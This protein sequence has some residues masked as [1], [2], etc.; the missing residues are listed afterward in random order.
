MASEQ[1]WTRPA[2]P[3]RPVRAGL[4]FAALAVAL[5]CVGVAGLGAWNVQVVGQ[6][7]GPVRDTADGFFRELTAGDTGGA[8]GRLCADARSR[9]SPIGFAQWVRTPPRVTGYEIVNVSVATSGGRPRGTVRIRLTR[10]G[11]AEE[12][13]K[14]PVVKEDGRW[15][16]CGDPF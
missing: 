3:R 14:L 1:P 16:I 6:A 13:R 9:W 4:L 11:G 7:S 12:E 8:Y 15:R 5:C 2:R 10:V